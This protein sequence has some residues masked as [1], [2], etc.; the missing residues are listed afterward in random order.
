M[1]VVLVGW[2]GTGIPVR[3]S[4][5]RV[6]AFVEVDQQLP[7]HNIFYGQIYIAA[8]C[9]GAFV[10]GAVVKGDKEF[11]AAGLATHHV[12]HLVYVQRLGGILY[13]KGDGAVLLEWLLLAAVCIDKEGLATGVYGHI[14]PRAKS[15]VGRVEVHILYIAGLYGAACIGQQIFGILLLPRGNAVSV[16]LCTCGD[17]NGQR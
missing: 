2:Y 4:A 9:V 3:E 12:Y 10:I 16:C 6:V 11:V 13:L 14:S 15:A 8:T 17:S 5:I 7:V 1:Q